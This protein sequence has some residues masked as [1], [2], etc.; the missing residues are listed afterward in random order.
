MTTATVGRTYAQILNNR[1]HKVF[2]S[3]ELPE[4]NPNNITVVDVTGNVPTEG[5][6]FNGS[7]FSPYL[8]PEKTQT[9]INAEADLAAMSLAQSALPDMLDIVSQLAA[10]T[11]ISKTD[12]D[13]IKAVNDSV[14]AEKAKKA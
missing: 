13:K 10:G 14:K 1:C 9:Q 8:A 5:D 7:T 4:W 6:S 12:Y 11:K 2:T 3:V